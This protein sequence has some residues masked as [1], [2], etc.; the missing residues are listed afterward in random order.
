MSNK[1][2]K[3]RK[4]AQFNHTIMICILKQ[5]MYI[6][7]IQMSWSTDQWKKNKIKLEVVFTKINCNN[8]KEHI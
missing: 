3:K 7:D 2:T 6:I 4:L 5:H 8:I 1:T